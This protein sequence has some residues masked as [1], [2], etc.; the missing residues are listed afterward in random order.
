MND[1][2][3]LGLNLLADNFG[4]ILLLFLLTVWK[5]EESIYDVHGFILYIIMGSTSNLGVL[6]FLD[7]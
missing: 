2:Y 1:I 4:K 5:Q 3:C 7:A 6:I